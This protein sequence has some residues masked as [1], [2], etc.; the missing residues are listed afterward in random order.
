MKTCGTDMLLVK[1]R[2]LFIKR[3]SKWLNTKLEIVA[4][5]GGLKGI[6][7]FVWGLLKCI[8]GKHTYSNI[9]YLKRMMTKCE[10]QYCRKEIN[11]L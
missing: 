6:I 9:F 2:I 3:D 4:N 5:G 8:F 11:E 7:R 1:N 10:C